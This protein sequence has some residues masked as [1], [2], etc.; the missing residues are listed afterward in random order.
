MASLIFSLYGWRSVYY[1][2]G[3]LTA[4]FILPIYLAMKPQATASQTTSQ[5]TGSEDAKQGINKHIHVGKKKKKL[6]LK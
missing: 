5:A 6:L 1:A 3:G 4:A 2:G